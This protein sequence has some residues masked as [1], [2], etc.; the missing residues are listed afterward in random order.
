MQLGQLQDSVEA[1]D[2][3][4]I[5][6]VV[7]TYDAP[8][9]QQ[10]FIDAGSITYPFISDIDATT[11]IALG[12]LNEDYGPGDSNYGIPHPGVFVVNPEQ[13]IVGKIFVE[14]FRT[15][16][17]GEGVLEYALDLLK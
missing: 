16:V 15:R 2:A 6:I 4:G 10:V 9:L 5:G 11:M 12:I 14:S 8:E 13:E 7:V 1:F 17:D 3:A